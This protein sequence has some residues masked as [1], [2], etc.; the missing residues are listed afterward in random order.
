MKSD[1]NRAALDLKRSE[2]ESYH[3]LL[4]LDVLYQTAPVGLGFVDH[5]LRYVRLNQVLAEINGL[6]LEAHIG[7]HASEINPQLSKAVVPMMEQVLVSRQPRLNVELRGHTPA[8][9]LQERIW[10]ASFYPV[11][12]GQTFG[13]SVAFQDV[14]TL[15]ASEDIQRRF[16]S[17]VESSDDA[18]I[19]LNLNSSITSWNRAAEDMFA[20]SAAEVMGKTIAILA[21]PNQRNEIPE[22]LK[23]LQKGEPAGHFETVHRRKD[24]SFID[25]WLTVS[26]IH[27]RGGCVIGASETVRNITEQKRDRSA[28]VRINDELRQ[29][30]YAAAHDLQEPLRNISLHAQ[31]LDMPT[32][33]PAEA[34]TGQ[35]VSVILGSA[36]RMQT[37][38]KD[39]LLYTEVV[40]LRRETAPVVDCNAACRTALENLV[41]AVDECKAK[42]TIAALPR[43]E[44]RTTHLVQLLQNLI[45]NALKYRSEDRKVQ[46]KISAERRDNDWVFSVRDNGIGIAPEYH[47]RIFRVFSRLHGRDTPGTGIGLAIC[48]RIVDHYGGRLWLES[49]VGRGSTFW[50]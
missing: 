8:D 36:A 38:L 5:E 26:P 40:D 32:K 43:I 18:M 44:V 29:F 49:E 15:K 9:I 2:E 31:M 33:G 47:D 17:I 41:A 45:G 7:R 1:G 27:D 48:K 46:I 24:G 34:E 12:N 4:E 22:L 21:A 50:F 23:R 37:L 11:A 20:Y 10:I 28:L 14:T 16:S 35:P 19:S 3:R 6:P 39:L 30:A 13:V 25:V 42:I